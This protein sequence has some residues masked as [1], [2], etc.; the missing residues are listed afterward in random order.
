MAISVRCQCGQQLQAKD[1]LAGKTVKCPKCQQP[2]RI[3]DSA[4]HGN[5]NQPGA[6]PRQPSASRQPVPD[7]PAASTI[8]VTCS[9][10]ASFNAKSEMA[11]KTVRCPKCSGALRIES[12]RSSSVFES[13]PLENNVSDP[14][15]T[16]PAPSMGPDAQAANMAFPGFA[17]TAS[18]SP[19]P[20]KPDAQ[21]KKKSSN[22]LLLL[23]IG[24][25]VLAVGMLGACGLGLYLFVG[26]SEVKV[27]DNQPATSGDSA[28]S[29]KTQVAD[30]NLSRPAMNPSQSSAP[31]IDLPAEIAG[32]TMRN[33]EIATVIAALKKDE[34]TPEYDDN[35]QVI[36][37]NA[38]FLSE[39]L[40]SQIGKLTTLRSLSLGLS[41]L[42][43]EDLV[44]LKPLTELR[45]LDLNDNEITGSGL[46]HLASLNKLEVLNLEQNDID[47]RGLAH[48]S[49][50]TSLRQLKLNSAKVTDEGMVHLGGLVNLELLDIS[51]GEISVPSLKHLSELKKLNDLTLPAGLEYPIDAIMMLTSLKKLDD[52][53]FAVTDADLEK[54]SN[55]TQLESVG[56]ILKGVTNA[57]LS[58]VKKMTGLKELLL[59]WEQSLTPDDFEF[60]GS[61]TGL[62]KLTLWYEV[63]PGAGLAHLEGLDHLTELWM[64]SSES[65]EADLQHLPAFP[66]LEKLRIRFPKLD[67]NALKHVAKQRNLKV[68]ELDFPN[69]TDQGLVHLRDL[70]KLEK[71]DLTSTKV[72]GS[73]FSNL[74]GM[75]NL[76]DLG[77]Y[78][79]KVVD[80]H[81]AE[82]AP[83]SKLKF[84]NLHGT[85]ISDAGIESL[86]K[87]SALYSLDVRETGV[88]AQGV[89]RLKQL[90][91]DCTV[92]GP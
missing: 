91:P 58:H 10:G 8:P 50:L 39:N 23:L 49:K 3:P 12:P 29:D 81:L 66:T 89:E 9:C 87:L 38:D 31:R 17:S 19:L 37:L 63:S 77:L 43:D 65:E 88:T 13:D 83:L 25:G 46:V 36:S 11:G 5:D 35:G 32:P 57:G 61:L 64:A 56:L 62:E 68:L 75:S 80:A 92:K 24:G 84:L 85:L 14:L 78:K 70:T 53:S 76:K 86:A 1:Q 22:L 79:T 54:L 44:H 48:L 40:L 74:A 90:L 18:A 69:F 60:L 30:A 6:A 52:D 45:S 73:G 34:K 47:G 72:D 16:T 27:V 15:A 41:E 28:T 21:G 20:A 42:G 51:S 67:D 2:L 26:R 59:S 82:L 7:Q 71:L 33:S 4:A 55:L